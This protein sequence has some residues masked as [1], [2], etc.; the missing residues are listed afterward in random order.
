M[1]TKMS[2]MMFVK[3]NFFQEGTP[4]FLFSLIVVVVTVQHFPVLIV[5]NLIHHLFAGLNLT[6]WS[7]ITLRCAVKRFSRERSVAGCGSFLGH[8]AFQLLDDRILFWS[9]ILTP[10]VSLDFYVVGCGLLPVP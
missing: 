10:L 5:N 6:R 9:E 1:N 2:N 4:C 3:L 7:L 8:N